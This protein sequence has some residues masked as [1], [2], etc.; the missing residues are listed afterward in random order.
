MLVL[1]LLTILIGVP[2]FLLTERCYPV[3]VFEMRMRLMR[4][5]IA[6]CKDAAKLKIKVEA[7]E[8]SKVEQLKNTID[9][10]EHKL[11]RIQKKL[12][13]SLDRKKDADWQVMLA[14]IEVAYNDKQTINQGVDAI[15]DG[16][17]EVDNE[18]KVLLE[19]KNYQLQYK[20]AALIGSSILTIAISYVV[21][22][23]T[24]WITNSNRPI[25]EL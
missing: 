15:I 19:T 10:K 18:L 17:N 11:R 8:P 20:Y 12:L 13:D 7:A 6:T 4:E 1:I 25:E 2:I 22:R 5:Y 24:F 21:M 9:E 3:K 14:K 16:L 23:V